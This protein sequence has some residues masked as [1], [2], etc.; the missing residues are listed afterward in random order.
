GAYASDEAAYRA[1]LNDPNLA[2]I[3]KF[4]LAGR[5]GPPVAK[6]GIGDHFTM[7]DPIGGGQRTY[8]VAAITPNDFTRNGVLLGSGG[9]RALLG[10]RAIANRA[11]ADVDDPS[12][13]VHAFAGRYLANG[14]EADTLHQVVQN[15][16]AN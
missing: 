15:E 2:I 11:Y 6:V 10:E 3:D 5:A 8:T 16:V 7:L 12:A 9:I 13:F 1:V 4:F 14:G